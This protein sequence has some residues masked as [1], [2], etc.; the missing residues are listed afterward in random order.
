MLNPLAG[1]RT[2]PKYVTGTN[3]AANTEILETVPVGKLWLVHALAFTIVQGAT[4]TPLPDLVIDDGTTVIYQAP[5]ASSAMNA[6]VTARF[7][8]A[9][10]LTLGAGAANT[11]INSPLPYGLMLP[12]GSRISTV[13]AGK[14]ANTD[15]SALLALVTELG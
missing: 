11:R 8:I 3:P 1:T 7:F 4:Q 9:P 15:L 13:T 2:V 6:S 10:F 12:A 14:G 5:C